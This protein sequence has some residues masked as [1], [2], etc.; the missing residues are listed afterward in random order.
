VSDNFA[1]NAR[2]SKAFRIKVIE[3]PHL[4]VAAPSAAVF[5]AC[6]ATLSG[7]TN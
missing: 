3:D 4:N 7:A 6:P 2:T 1:Y 5:P